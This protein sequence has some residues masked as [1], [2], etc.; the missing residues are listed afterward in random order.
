MKKLD[1]FFDV[2]RMKKPAGMVEIQQRVTYNLSY[3]VSN[4]AAIVA[5]SFLYCIFTNLKFFTIL[6]L[7]IGAVY[8]LHTRF[9]DTGEINLRVFKLGKNMWYPVLVLIMLPV[10][11]VQSPLS[12]VFWL[13][14]SCA[15]IVLLHAAVMDIPAEAEYSNLV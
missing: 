14:V 10:L 6:F 11:F 7:E 1:D 4:Y 12:Q 5:L 2:S 9:G 13:S 8:Y 3:F 15:S